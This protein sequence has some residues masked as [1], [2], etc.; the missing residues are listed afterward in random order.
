MTNTG[1]LIVVAALVAA[2]AG[3]LVIK[4]RSADSSAIGAHD[5]IQTAERPSAP[6]AST[7]GQDA[8]PRLVDVGA[9][10]CVPCKM[11]MPVLAELKEEYAGRLRVEYH[12][13]GKDPNLV[14]EYDVSI[15]P[16]QIFYDASGTELFRHEG[17]Y[18]KD[19]IVAKWRELGVEL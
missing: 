15:I 14:A 1:K 2:I 12:D 17:F 5:S 7:E 13:V 4:N 18:S 3:V 8:L 16:V 10:T 19:D 9:G 6:N 11:M